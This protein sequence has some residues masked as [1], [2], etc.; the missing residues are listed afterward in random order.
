M[1]IANVTPQ[2]RFSDIRK[3]ATRVDAALNSDN[4]DQVLVD[5]F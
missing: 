5:L 1:S 4:P 2:I 3:M